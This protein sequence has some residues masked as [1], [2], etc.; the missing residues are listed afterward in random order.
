MAAVLYL[1]RI[2]WAKAAPMIQRDYQLTN[3]QLAYLAMA[4]QIAYGLFEIPT[5]RWGEL[6]GARRVLTRITIWWS[7]FTALT[8]A[9]FGF[10]SLLVIR[11]LFGAGEAGAYPNAARVL[12]R[13]FPKDERGRVQGAMLFVSL[14]GGALAP[15]LAAQLIETIGWRWNF[16]V[17]GSLGVVWATGFWLWY[18]DTPDLHPS[19]NALEREWIRAGGG[20]TTAG[21]HEPIP[22]RAVAS[23]PGIWLLSMIIMCSSFNSY[24]YFTW[25]PTYLES[26]HGITNIQSGGLTSMVLA[27]AAI[28]MLAGGVAADQIARSPS[29]TKLR[30]VFCSTAFLAAAAFLFAAVRADSAFRLS[31]LAACSCFC[32]QLTLPSWWSAAIEQSGTHVGPI[33]GLMNMMGTVGALATQWFVGAFADFQKARGLTGRDQWDAM[34]PAYIVVLLI[35]SLGWAMYH[36]AT[37]GREA[38]TLT[39]G[40]TNER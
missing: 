37:A 35:G 30:R 2:C 32:F 18:R 26:A 20:A 16:V 12:T 21:K 31:A 7:V 28:G 22:W 40:K 10:S 23:D 19:A 15:A 6:L 33:F 24:F 9:A 36:S 39:N 38:N 34:F 3:T 14:V 11:F 27:G 4:F 13:W 25:F 17:F 5:G 8:G 29:S 1:D